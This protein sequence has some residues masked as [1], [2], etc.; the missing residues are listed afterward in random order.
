MTCPHD[1]PLNEHCEDCLTEERD[2]WKHK[3]WFIFDL[4]T[5]GVDP[6]TD[7]ICQLGGVWMLNGEMTD[8]RL[9]TINPGVPIP[10]GASRVHGITDE[11]VAQAPTFA[12]VFPK[13]LEHF[14][15]AEVVL[16]YNGSRFDWPL[17][18]AQRLDLDEEMREMQVGVGTYE[19][20]LHEAVAE[21]LFVDV[22]TQVRRKSVG[23]WWKGSGRHRLENV[24]AR[25]DIGLPPGMRPHRADADCYIAGR[26]LW[27]TRGKLPHTAADVRELLDDRQREQ[28]EDYQ[29]WRELQDR[30][31][32]K[33]A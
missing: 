20:R 6:A 21:T 1:I 33:T 17:L 23:R 9:V 19:Y 4:E 22:L 32:G 8:R 2:G 11:R 31:E 24:A 18:E 25:M 5:T 10:E 7:R 16:T 15:R 13:V 3:P 26:I 29:R 27:E 12:E 30:A 28:E 14:R